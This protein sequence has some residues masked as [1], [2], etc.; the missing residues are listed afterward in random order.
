MKWRYADK[1]ELRWPI[2]ATS[3]DAPQAPLRV[4]LLWMAG[5]WAASASVLL[6]VAYVLRLVLK[7]MV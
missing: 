4:R 5:I 6:V 1:L 3:A 2:I 7:Q